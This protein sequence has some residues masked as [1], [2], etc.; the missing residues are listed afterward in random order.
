MIVLTSEPDWLSFEKTL[1]LH[2]EAL[3]LFGG[4][5]GIRD[6]NL[7]RSALDRPRNLW[8]YG[9]ERRLA[10]LA[11]AYAFGL[12]KNHAFIDGNKRSAAVCTSVFVNRTGHRFEPPIDE[13]IDAYQNLAAGALS[14]ADFA[15]FVADHLTPR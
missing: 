14:E 12:A 10:V 15:A 8:A 3:R 4:A 13:A 9:E 11:A 7:L 1:L 6:E 5:S 2:E